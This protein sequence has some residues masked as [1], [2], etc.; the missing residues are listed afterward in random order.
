MLRHDD[1]L[2][3][4]RLRGLRMKEEL[5]RNAGGALTAE[6]VGKLLGL[7][8]QAVDKR[9]KPRRLVAM[10]FGKRGFLY[11][12][13]QLD[14]QLT[15]LVKRVLQA[16]DERVQDW[17]LLAFFLNGNPYL[18]GVRPAAA[19]REGKLEEVLRAA[20]AYGRQGAP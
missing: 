18:N 9:R 19:L 4:A 3:A 11:P 13:F 2:A 16:I 12:T 17:S 14:E 5:L 8:R 15:P 10:R 7:T 6:E 20:R 1:P